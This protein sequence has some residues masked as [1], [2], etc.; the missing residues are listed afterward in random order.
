M[1][2]RSSWFEKNNI[3]K[4]CIGWLSGGS[5]GYGF[6]LCFGFGKKPNSRSPIYLININFDNDG[7]FVCATNHRNDYTGENPDYIPLEKAHT[8]LIEVLMED[9][10]AARK[11]F[12][13]S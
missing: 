12:I 8:H 11:L 4:E 9:S 5:N 10:I 6:T 1:N 7:E 3:D 2:T 13:G